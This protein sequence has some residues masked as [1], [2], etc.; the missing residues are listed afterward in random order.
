MPYT[1]HPGHLAA[2]TD[3]EVKDKTLKCARFTDEG[4]LCN[5]DFTW[6]AR[7]Q[8]LHKCLGYT[9]IPKSCPL[10]K[11]QRNSSYANA[12]CRKVTSGAP[13]DCDWNDVEKCKLFQAGKCGFGDQC[14]FSHSETSDEPLAFAHPISMEEEDDTMIC[15]SAIMPE[16]EE[17]IDW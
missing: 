5:A 3:S 15:W 8:L 7:E 2:V 14:K 12:P 4:R 1:A 10:H 6:T 13:E 11:P 17:D 16:E 9:S